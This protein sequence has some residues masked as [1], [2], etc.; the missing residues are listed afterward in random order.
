MFD[1]VDSLPGME[2]PS[3]QPSGLS[4]DRRTMLKTVAITTAGTGVL[5]GVASA[6]G[7]KDLQVN[8]CG[9]SQ[10]CAEKRQAKDSPTNPGSAL[11]PITVF[12]AEETDNGWAF[13]GTV[14]NSGLI[15][16]DSGEE[17]GK[18]IIG[19]TPTS[20]I[21]VETGSPPF[22]SDLCLVCN[23]TPCAANALSAYKQAYE[24][25]QGEAVEC[26]NDGGNGPEFGEV[27]GVQC[28][29]KDNLYTINV[30]R[31]GCGQPGRNPGGLGEERSGLP[32]EKSPGR[33]G[34]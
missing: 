31:G 8:F 12:V 18:K 24:D 1:S 32:G 30:V 21:F 25:N 13:G 4:I 29:G 15:C 6:E 17:K 34:N 3:N 9:C 19:V 22:P 14:Y 10:V 20:E 27:T 11:G 5:S 2:T 7:P 26:L 33:P 16:D 23:P 28:G